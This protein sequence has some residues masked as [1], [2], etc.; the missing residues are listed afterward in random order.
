MQQKFKKTSTQILNDSKLLEAQ[1]YIQNHLNL[2][3]SLEV[4]SGAIALSP[5]YFHRIFKEAL[6]ETVK[7]YID[8][9]RVAKALYD[10]RLS[11]QSLV[12]IS[13][14]YGFKNP[15]TFSRVFKRY[16]GAPPS[17]FL[18]RSRKLDTENEIDLK[19]SSHTG[20]RAS[21]SRSF[22][23]IKLKELKLAFIRHIGAYEK[24][25]LVS[26]QGDTIWR[27][28]ESFTKEADLL[29]QPYCYLGIPHDSPKATQESKLRYDAC[30][31]VKDQFRPTGKIGFQ[32]LEPMYYGV[33]TH[34]GPYSS[35]SIGYEK[36]FSCAAKLKGFV[37]DTRPV[38]ELLIDIDAKTSAGHTWTELY[39]PLRKSINEYS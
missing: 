25:P 34:A 32:T 21:K 26:G 24:I 31:V 13:M 2:D 1:L 4:V 30:L 3:L 29:E 9:L 10:M 16:Y 6:G 38:L 27:Q 22:S 7:Q 18:D 20:L 8:R 5:Y 36:L 15:E 11:S 28:L 33:L 23:V 37:I 12:S 17:L 14:H 19:P 35:L 39:V